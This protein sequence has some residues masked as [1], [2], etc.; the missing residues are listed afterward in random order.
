MRF[1]FGRKKQAAGVCRGPDESMDFDSEPADEI[2]LPQQQPKK[3]KSV[4]R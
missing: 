3:A 2:R 4:T 1:R